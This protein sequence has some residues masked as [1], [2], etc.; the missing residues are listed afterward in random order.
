M[1]TSALIL[2]SAAFWCGS[3]AWGAEPAARRHQPLAPPLVRMAQEDPALAKQQAYVVDAQDELVKLDA[4]V[5]RLLEIR[6]REA[7]A[8]RDFAEAVRAFHQKA[9]VL[10]EKLDAV[11]ASPADYAQPAMEE[12]DKALAELRAAYDVVVDRAGP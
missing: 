4:G 2:L 11:R 3:T 7:A 5:S 8:N 12:A 10:R 9:L 1:R 6:P